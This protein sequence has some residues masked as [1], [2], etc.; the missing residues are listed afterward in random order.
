MLRRPYHI[1]Y[2]IPLRNLKHHPFKPHVIFGD[3]V[4]ACEYKRMS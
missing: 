3:F 1:K 2:D 4:I